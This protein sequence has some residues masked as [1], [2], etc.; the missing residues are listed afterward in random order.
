[1][2]FGLNVQSDFDIA[3]DVAARSCMYMLHLCYIVRTSM[4]QCIRYSRFPKSYARI[5]QWES[6]CN[7]LVPSCTSPSFPG[8]NCC[9]TLT[10][11]RWY[12]ETS[13]WLLTVTWLHQSLYSARKVSSLIKPKSMAVLDSNHRY[14]NLDAKSTGAGIQ[15]SK[16]KGKAVP[17]PTTTV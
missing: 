13:G 15:N 2:I 6:N 17:S 11:I 12:L 14:F 9:L 8:L 16:G 4:H 1:M 5:L 3:R 10:V 7:T